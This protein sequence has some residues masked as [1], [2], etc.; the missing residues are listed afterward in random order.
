MD[1]AFFV[2]PKLCA[3]TMLMKGFKRKSD[4]NGYER[5]RKD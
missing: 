4:Y 5:K 2:V 3:G 1:F